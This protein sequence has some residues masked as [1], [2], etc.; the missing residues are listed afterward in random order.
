MHGTPLTAN[1]VTLLA[2]VVG[3]VI[4]AATML[5]VWWLTHKFGPNYKKQIADLTETLAK[6]LQQHSAIAEALAKISTRSELKWRPTA[7]IESQPRENRLVLKSDREFK[8]EK[9]AFL[10]A[11]GAVISEIRQKEWEG[12]RTTGYR[13]P[14]PQ[15]KITQLWNDSL[16]PRNGWATG[17]TQVEFCRDDGSIGDVS[18]PFMAKQEFDS[19]GSATHAWIRLTG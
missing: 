5:A 4:A 11:N 3:A 6:I 14:L 19:Q 9:I 2:A 1:E 15:D 10:A 16:G 8:I 17:T 18:V 7:W 13:L 12:Q